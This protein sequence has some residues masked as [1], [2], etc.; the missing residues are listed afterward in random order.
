VKAI[1]LVLLT[2]GRSE[3]LEECLASLARQTQKAARL[4]LVNDGP[5]LSRAVVELAQAVCPEVVHAQTAQPRSGQW[6][7]LRVGLQKLQNDHPF[8]V[9]HDDDR[10]K[11]HYI[12]TLSKFAAVQNAPWICCHNLE[13]FT[14]GVESTHRILPNDSQPFVV[15]SREEACLR[16][17]HSF[18]P[19][20]GTCFGVPPSAVADRLQEKYQEMAD[21]VLLCECAQIAKVFYEPDPIYEYRRHPQQVSGRMDHSM[22]DHLQAYLLEKTCGTSREGRVG[23]NL[24]KRRAERYF[25]WAWENRRFSEYPFCRQFSWRFALRPLRNRKRL[26]M[27]ILSQEIRSRIRSW[28]S[29][30]KPNLR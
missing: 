27:T 5:P 4:V 18:M 13:V 30:G 15:N 16:Y 1:S 17:S 11:E 23:R 25:S 24:E 22:E 26:A 20:P 2:A 9:V 7:A 8:A 21:V 10:L 14:S 28:L 6:P 29:S 3:Y 19:F 12:E